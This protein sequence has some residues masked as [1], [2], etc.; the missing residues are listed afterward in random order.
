MMTL[1]HTAAALAALLCATSV[2]AQAVSQLAQGE[3]RKIDKAAG[4]IT[5][6]HGT[7]P[8]IDMPPMTMVFAVKDPSL[9][10][11]VQPGD[12]IR[13]DV[14]Q[15]GGKLIVTRIEADKL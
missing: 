8:S 15:E 4:K 10:E 6:K 7:I 13:F 5:L 1:R 2:W 12:K 3:V 9:L 11:S 14:I